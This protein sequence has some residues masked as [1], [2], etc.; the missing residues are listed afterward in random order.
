MSFPRLS[1]FIL[2]SLVLSG[3]ATLGVSGCAGPRAEVI[4]VKAPVAKAGVVFVVDGAGDFRA[5][6]KNLGQV[7]ETTPLQVVTVPWSHGYGRIIADG[8]DHAYAVAK[9]ERLAQVIGKYKHEYPDSPIY[10]VAHS[11][12][13]AVVITTLEKLPPE[14]VHR[15]F[16]LSPSLSAS[17]DVRPALKAVRYGL[18]V[19]YSEHDTAYLGVWTGILG[20]SDRRWGPSSG[21]IG[22]QI[23]AVGPEDAHLYAKFF[24]RPWQ[25]ND[26]INGNDGKHYG[27]YQPDFVRA[28]IL[29]LLFDV[30]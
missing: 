19:F 17:Y 5:C 23:P 14:T 4:A 25:P 20:N 27:D 13:S 9:G 30:N 2:A 29:P 28:H 22:F 15:A 10:L 1:R 16:L 12:G 11:A 26:R 24:Q 18:H 21:R 8:I 6:S 7:C 3:Q